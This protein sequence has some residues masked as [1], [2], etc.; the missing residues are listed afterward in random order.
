[1]KLVKKSICLFV[2]ALTA[3]AIINAGGAGSV[4][5]PEKIKKLEEIK[6]KISA[7]ET[8]LN[9]IKIRP[10]KSLWNFLERRGRER[11]IQKRNMIIRKNEKLK[12]EKLKLMDELLHKRQEYTGKMDKKAGSD[13]FRHILDYLDNLAAQKLI[14]EGYMPEKDI[15]VA[16]SEE[17]LEYKLRQE[18]QRAKAV[19]SLI[20]HYKAKTE[21][22]TGHEISPSEADF[23][24]IT[25]KLGELHT[26]LKKSAE[27][28]R[29]QL[30]K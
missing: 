27:M 20:N 9:N 21:A 7:N 26:N 3:G 1:M 19:K 24:D 15:N 23:S 6:N 13:K 10:R 29:I 22:Y 28:I 16:E 11:E 17:F 18:K 2:Y 14:S 30:S 5:V 25:A 4:P 8:I 12:K